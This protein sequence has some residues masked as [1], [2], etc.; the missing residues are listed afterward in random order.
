M[1]VREAILDSGEKRMRRGGFN[2]CSFRDI[3]GDVGIKSASVHYYFRTKADLATA[4]VARYEARVLATIGDPEDGRD[5][6]AKLGAMRAAFR[7]GLTRGDGMC[8]CGVLATERHSVPPAVGGA[9]Q[10]YFA[11]CNAWLAVVFA[12]ASL[13]R[14]E[15]KAL[16]FTA[17]LQGAMLQAIALNDVGAFDDA[18]EGYASEFGPGGRG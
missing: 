7:G 15:K 13:P 4:L 11:A 18:V 10:R 14:P 2:A 12:R 16:R 6:A 9:T 1:D 5:L 3:A 17:I 8:L